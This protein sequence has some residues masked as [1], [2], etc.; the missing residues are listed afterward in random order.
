M[1]ANQTNQIKV[2]MVFVVWLI[3]DDDWSIY[4]SDNDFILWNMCNFPFF[5]QV[6]V[7]CVILLFLC[8]FVFLYL[9]EGAQ[10]L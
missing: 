1:R 3:N 4:F 10:D 7:L 2:I 9:Q 6:A 5:L 8:I